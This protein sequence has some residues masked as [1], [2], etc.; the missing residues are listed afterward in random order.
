M[1]KSFQNIVQN[2]KAGVLSP[3]L[4]A[5]V[6]FEAFKN[7]LLEAKNWIITPQGTALYR[8]GFQHI[9]IPP[10]NQPF[11]LFQFHRGGDES[12]ILLEVS[13]GLTRF[14][15]ED[16]DG[17]FHLFSEENVFLI[18][19]DDDFELVDEDAVFQLRQAMSDWVG[20]IRTGDEMARALR[21]IKQLD[22]DHGGASTNFDNMLAAATLITMIYAIR[23]LLRLRVTGVSTF[24]IPGQ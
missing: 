10:S 1:P 5:G 18:D 7:A 15:V 19:E 12:D 9:G 6:D 21:F 11:R 24:L 20:V 23:V 22:T 16:T 2:F 3:R 8:E 4:S 14:W 13:E 17:T